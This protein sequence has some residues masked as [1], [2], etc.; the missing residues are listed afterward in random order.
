MSV[1]ILQLNFTRL[2]GAEYSSYVSQYII[3]NSAPW[4][5]YEIDLILNLKET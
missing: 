2:Y 1:L 4:S 3:F 5:R